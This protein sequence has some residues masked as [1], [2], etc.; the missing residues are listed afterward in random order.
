MTSLLLI[1]VLLMLVGPFVVV[2]AVS[3]VAQFAGGEP[4]FQ[5]RRPQR[6]YRSR[7][8]VFA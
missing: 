5:P 6:S 3:V 2:G 7:G 1:N 8:L 4:V